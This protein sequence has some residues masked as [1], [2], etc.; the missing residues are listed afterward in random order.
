MLTSANIVNLS[1]LSRSVKNPFAKLTHC[2]FKTLGVLGFVYGGGGGGGGRGQNF[3]ISL[4]ARFL[5][6]RDQ[7]QSDLHI[8]NSDRPRSIGKKVHFSIPWGLKLKAPEITSHSA[9]ALKTIPEPQYSVIKLYHCRS[10][11]DLKTE[12]TIS[13]C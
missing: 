6:V 13:S 9:R 12:S 10:H 3:L 2:R 8:S 5:Y 4:H 1:T 11:L 7:Q